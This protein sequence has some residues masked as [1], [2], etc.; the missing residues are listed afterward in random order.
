[1]ALSFK[2]LWKKLIDID[3]SKTELRKLLGISS[4]TLARMRKDEYVSLKII[5][6]ICR[7]LSCTPNDIIEFT[8]D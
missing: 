3:M 4:S 2:P 6:D 7:E 1:M 5:N 8:P